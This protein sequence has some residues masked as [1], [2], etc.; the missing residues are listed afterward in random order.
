[1]CVNSHNKNRMTHPLRVAK[2]CT[3][4]PLPRVQKLMTHPLSALAHPPPPPLYFLTSPLL[5]NLHYFIS[6]LSHSF[7][8]FQIHF[9]SDNCNCQT[10]FT[11]LGNPQTTA[12]DIKCIT[13]KFG[14]LSSAHV[15]FVTENL[16]GDCCPDFVSDF[17]E[18]CLEMANLSKSS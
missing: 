7:R 3:T 8:R 4:H 13:C 14:S 18:A 6:L 2:N 5:V 9:A 17:N 12:Q 16:E 1:M 10:P 15:K 11:F